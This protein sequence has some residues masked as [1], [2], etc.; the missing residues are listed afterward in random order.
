MRYQDSSASYKVL[1]K[2]KVLGS[3]LGSALPVGLQR[4]VVPVVH[5]GDNQLHVV[6]RC[7]GDHSVHALERLLRHREISKEYTV[8]AAVNFDPL[9]TSAT[10]IQALI[11]TSGQ[12]VTSTAEAY[13]ETSQSL[14]FARLA[15][16]ASQSFTRAARSCRAKNL[17]LLI[18]DTGSCLQVEAPLHGKSKHAHHCE[19]LTSCSTTYHPNWCHLKVRLRSPKDL[20]SISVLPLTRAGKGATLETFSD[21]DVNKGGFI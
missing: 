7:L 20:T 4:V 13:F 11:H 1:G 16:R 8:I 21:E 5:E 2:N 9:F 19:V 15:K 3:G 17:H 12:S 14:S 18:V 10:S 6:A